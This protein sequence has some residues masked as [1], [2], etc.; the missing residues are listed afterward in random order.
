[1]PNSPAPIASSANPAF[2]INR[3]ARLLTRFFDRQLAGQ[4]ISVAYL[5]VLGALRAAHALS[6]KELAQQ[7]QIGQPA[8]A[9]MLERMV[10]EGLLLR[11]PDPADGRKA[12][13]SLSARASAQQEAVR[14][15]LV[16]GNA[17]AFADIDEAQL[18]QLLD[19]LSTVEARLRVLV[20]ADD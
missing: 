2:Q 20:G 16:K 15:A 10:K 6:Q 7:A 17:L 14:Q 1:M 13:F 3:V 12:L 5:P 8:M 19:S 18:R 9:Q 11:A 4:G